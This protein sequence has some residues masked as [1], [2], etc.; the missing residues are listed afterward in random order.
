MF[1]G[2]LGVFLFFSAIF[3]LPKPELFMYNHCD[4]ILL[5]LNFVGTI[6]NE[7]SKKTQKKTTIKYRRGSSFFQHI[8]TLFFSLF[9]CVFFFGMVASYLT[10]TKK[11]AG[12]GVGD[13]SF[14]KKNITSSWVCPR[15]NQGYGVITPGVVL[16]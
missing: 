2:T 5:L 16:R 7:A 11:V 4:T 8:L 9:F 10:I 15:N 1:L 14:T 3:S 13:F 6:M 12:P